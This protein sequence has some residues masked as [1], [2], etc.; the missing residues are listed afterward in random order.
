MLKITI[1]FILIVFPCLLMAQTVVT[2]VPSVTDAAINVNNDAH[3]TYAPSGTLKNKLVVFLP[4]TGAIPMNYSLFERAA[5]TLGFHSIG[6]TYVNDITIN[7]VV[8]VCGSVTDTGCYRKAR[9]E[10]LTGQDLTPLLTISRTNSIENRLIKLLKYLHLQYP[11]QGWG[12]YLDGDVVLWNKIITAGHSQGAGHAAFI[13]KT[14]RVDR[15]LMFSW[16]D[17]STVLNNAAPWVGAVGATTSE[18]FF[19]FIH[20]KDGLIQYSTALTTWNLLGLSLYGKVVSIDTANGNFRGTHTL[21]TNQEPAFGGSTALAYHNMSVANLYTPSTGLEAGFKPVWEY[22]LTTPVRTG[23]ND[24]QAH[25]DIRLYPN[26]MSGDKLFID[27]D[28]SGM[29]EREINVIVYD[30]MGRIVFAQNDVD[31]QIYMGKA[32]LKNGMYVVRFVNKNGDTFVKRLS[33]AN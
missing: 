4:G 8:D 15:A 2:V 32:L 19:S 21:V 27:F 6:L 17:Y 31:K 16:A 29:Q 23:I 14:Y 18:G 26:P 5:A 13:G 22:M 20:P 28:K 25:S 10:V 12:Q 30:N 7:G 1:H 9:L 33:V 3:Y 24:K 11:T